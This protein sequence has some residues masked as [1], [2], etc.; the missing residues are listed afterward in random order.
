VPET[1]AFRD[2]AEPP[3]FPGPHTGYKAASFESTA[4]TL[5]GWIGGAYPIH[6]I[7][8]METRGDTAERQERRLRVGRR[9][10][11]LAVTSSRFIS[12]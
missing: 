10:V 12:K 5:V 8:D 11:S 2:E 6:H 1:R 9:S 3:K 4:V 7:Q